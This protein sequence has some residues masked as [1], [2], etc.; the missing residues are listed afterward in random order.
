MPGRSGPMMVTIS[1][2]VGEG[3]SASSATTTGRRIIGARVA[4][5]GSWVCAGSAP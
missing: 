2:V 1:G 3:A 5:R 4:K